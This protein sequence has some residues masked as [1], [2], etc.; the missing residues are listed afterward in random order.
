[1]EFSVFSVLLNSFKCVKLSSLLDFPIFNEFPL[2]GIRNLSKLFIFQLCEYFRC[3][4]P[5]LRSR[6]VKESFGEM[7]N[8]VEQQTK[9]RFK[10]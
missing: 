2:A 6:A 1:M 7:E 10:C 3:K 4:I 9:R 8:E 5:L